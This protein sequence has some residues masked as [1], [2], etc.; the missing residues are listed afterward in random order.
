MVRERIR[1]DGNLSTNL[2]VKI[3]SS[4][5]Y[6]VK[7]QTVLSSKLGFNKRRVEHRVVW[8]I[9]ANLTRT[10]HV[11]SIRCWDKVGGSIWGNACL[12]RRAPSSQ[13]P[14]ITIRLRTV[15]WTRPRNR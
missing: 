1:N 9:R 8:K 12:V 10:F 3:Y 4:V 6:F 11:D 7:L 14:V 15:S 2:Q 5:S 13:H